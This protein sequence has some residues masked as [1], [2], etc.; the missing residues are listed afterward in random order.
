MHARTVFPAALLATAFCGPARA[1]PA[2]PAAG[3][4]PV[5]PPVVVSASRLPAG[6]TGIFGTTAAWERADIARFAPRTI[7]ELLAVAPSFSLYRRQTALFGHPT[8]AGVSLGGLGA[9]AASRTLVTRDGIPQNDPFGGWVN[10][11]RHDPAGLAAARILPFSRASAWGNLSPA[12]VIQLD[13]ADLGSWPS[14]VRVIHPDVSP[15]RQPRDIRGRLAING[16][17]PGAIGGSGAV[18]VPAGPGVIELS[19]FARHEDGFPLVAKS[20]RGA[21]DRRGDLDYAG[22]GLRGRWFTPSG[23]EI[24]PS[25]SW[26]DEE[27]GNGTPL[28][29]NRSRALDFGLRLGRLDDAGD[30]RWEAAA[31][32]QRRDFENVFTTVNEA[33]D[34]EVPV[35]DQFD[36]PAEGAGA[37]FTRWWHED[38]P[39]S[40][41]AGADLRHASGTTHEFAGAGPAGFLRQRVAGGEQAGAGLFGGAAWHPDDALRVEAGARLDWWTFTG[42][43]LRERSLV[44]GLPLAD[45]DYPDRDGWEPAA[46]LDLSH[47]PGGG[48]E[49]GLGAATSFRLPTLN[50]LYR[51]FRVRDDLTVANAGLES[52]RFTGLEARA[53]WEAGDAS[54]SLR[55]ALFHHWIADGIANVP[56][57]DP[58]EA[59][60]L[61]GFLPPGATV[62][63]RRNV[64]AAVARGLSAGLVARL[65]ADLAWSADYRYTESRFTSS[66]D[67]PSLEGRDFPQ[68]PRHRLATA[69]DWQAADALAVFAGLDFTGDAYDDGLNLR[70]LPGYASVRLGATLALADNLTLRLRV[71]NLFDGEI[72]TGESADGLRSTG[73][74]R[75]FWAGLEWTF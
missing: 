11:A 14:Q 17:A 2:A 24:N 30:A 21:I 31:W 22:A 23:L 43:S 71:E 53:G 63:Q 42:G 4:A 12:G 18:L 51:P 68:V 44:T 48:W 41:L 25:L 6:E 57:T 62:A 59:A 49:F 7:D 10:W 5:L 27:R 72:I 38:Q 54:W 20:Q 1:N 69:L 15:D 56:V 75:S 47:R 16:G 19:G 3:A 13:S 46:S 58:G 28:A 55:G 70:R 32:F 67:Q 61:A 60:A 73:T 45:A 34:A 35:L 37:S 66:P 64:D 50:E 52:E 39:L 29:R 40:W 65:T 36:V 33:R 8:S 9:T 74:P 26:Y